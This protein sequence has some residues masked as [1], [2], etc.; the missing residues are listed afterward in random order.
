MKIRVMT[1]LDIDIEAWCSEYGVDADEARAQAYADAEQWAREAHFAEPK[2][3]GMVTGKRVV[4]QE[5][6]G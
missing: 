3:D 2:W 5:V 4:V 1:T 6:A